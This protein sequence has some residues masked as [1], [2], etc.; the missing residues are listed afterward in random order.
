MVN[1]ARRPASA[2]V[3]LLLLTLG[4]TGVMAWQAQSAARRH[5]AAAEGALHDYARFAAFLYRQAGRVALMRTGGGSLFRFEP[6][7]PARPG[8]PLPTLAEALARPQGE[9]CPMCPAIDS[10]R[11]FFRLDLRDGSVER[12]GTALPEP[13]RAWL[14]DTARKLTRSPSRP[15][16]GLEAY[17][18]LTRAGGTDRALTYL[19]RREPGGTAVGLYGFEANPR[20]LV[21][22]AF[23]PVYASQNVLPPS[24]T[25]GLAA[26][27]MVSLVVLDPGGRELYASPRQ[28][29]GGIDATD[30][31]GALVGGMRVRVSLRAGAANRLMI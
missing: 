13:A 17:V 27:S 8:A 22:A 25:R 24:L 2:M 5:R 19:V 23:R 10:I 9:P 12:T 14:A 21:Q 4:V 31:L 28:Y 6:V 1:P 30:T 18:L 16:G 7:H 15:E 3:V 29:A 11:G 20:T 26:D